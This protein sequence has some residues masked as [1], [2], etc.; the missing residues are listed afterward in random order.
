MTKIARCKTNPNEPNLL[1]APSPA[2]PEPAGMRSPLGRPGRLDNRRRRGFN[3][4]A[5]RTISNDARQGS[6]PERLKGTG[7]K[8]VGASLRWFES[9][10]AHHCFA[11]SPKALFCAEFRR[12]PNRLRRYARLRVRLLCR[13]LR[14][15]CRGGLPGSP[16]KVPA[17]HSQAVLARRRS[18]AAHREHAGIGRV[19]SG[20]PR[21]RS[22]GGRN[23]EDCS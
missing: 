22:R 15:L 7:C 11:L 18:G 9:N 16:L 19:R 6:V 4:A 20:G 3:T 12:F 1:I 8:P 13:I 2:L 17:G 21:A 23:C 14:R 5:T 10:P